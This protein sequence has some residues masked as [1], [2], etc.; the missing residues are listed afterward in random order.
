MINLNEMKYILLFLFVVGVGCSK[1]DETCYNCK[2][3]YGDKWPQAKQ[4]KETSRVCDNAKIDYVQTWEN[5]I[6]DDTLNYSVQ[7][8][9]E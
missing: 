7:C 2:V 6:V 4:V 1:E 9:L 3:I 8:E 5:L